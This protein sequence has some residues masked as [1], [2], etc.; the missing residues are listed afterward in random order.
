MTKSECG[1]LGGKKTAE[2]YGQKYM[3]AL[4]LKGATAM[5]K[6]YKLVKLSTSDFA[7]VNRETGEATGKTINGRYLR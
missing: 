5:H 4:A 2:K 6:K 1:S 7:I 3:S